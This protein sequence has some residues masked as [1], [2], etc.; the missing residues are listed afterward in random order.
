MGRYNWKITEFRLERIFQNKKTTST[1]HTLLEPEQ[2]K[3]HSN[4]KQVE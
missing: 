4:C 1:S 3:A 2:K